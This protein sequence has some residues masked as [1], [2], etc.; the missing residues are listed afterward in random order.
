MAGNG[1]MIM[2]LD[3]KRMTAMAQKDT[4]ALQN[5]TW[6]MVTWQSTKLPE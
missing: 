2:E 6:R 1:E 4:A 3:K 5:G